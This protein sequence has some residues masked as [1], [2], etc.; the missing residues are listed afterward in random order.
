MLLFSFYTVLGL[1]IAKSSFRFLESTRLEL[2]DKEGQTALGDPRVSDLIA[3]NK[4]IGKAH[5]K[6]GMELRFVAAGS[7]GTRRR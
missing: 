1:V 7:S 6:H 2:R 4:A 5:A 3:R